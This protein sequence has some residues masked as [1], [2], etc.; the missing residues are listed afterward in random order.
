[1]KETDHYDT[2]LDWLNDNGFKTLIGFC[3]ILCIDNV[4]LQSAKKYFT[5]LCKFEG[6]KLTSDYLQRNWQQIES[7]LRRDRQFDIWLKGFI[8][9]QCTSAENIAV[10]RINKDNSIDVTYESR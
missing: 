3:D 4:G 6:V 2:L 5:I 10:A 7:Q 1:M 9:S 8:Q